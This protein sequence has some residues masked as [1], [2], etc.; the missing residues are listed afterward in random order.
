MRCVLALS[1]V[2]SCGPALAL[3]PEELAGQF[4]QQLARALAVPDE[5]QAAYLRG[6]LEQLRRTGADL[7]RQQTVVV[8]DRNPHVQALL[9]YAGSG[10]APAG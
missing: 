3:T 2:L 6:A 10:R 9:V 4:H 1:L 7:A 8:V 5:Q